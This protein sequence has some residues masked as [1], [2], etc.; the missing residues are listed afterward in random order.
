MDEVRR[1]QS[2]A[3][4]IQELTF[5]ISALEVFSPEQGSLDT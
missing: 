5:A 2:R 4:E 1:A 3:G